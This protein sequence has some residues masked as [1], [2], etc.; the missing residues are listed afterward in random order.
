[1]RG[2]RSIVA[3]ALVAIAAV[4][5]AVSSD[6]G[7]QATA[8][9]P[10]NCHRNVPPL[11]HDGFPEPPVRYSKGGLLVTQ[12]R[13]SVSP[14]RINHQLVSTLNYD[15]SFPGPTLVICKGDR[16][17]VH[18]INDLPEPTNLHTH[19]FHVSP[20]GNHDNIFLKINPGQRF[21][22]EY[23][24]PQDMPAG[25]YWYHPHLHM[26]VERQIFAG[27]AGAIVEEGG[28][29][30]LPAL[31]KI[32]Q[33]WIVIQNTW[34]KEGKTEPVEQLTKESDAKLYVNGVID[35]TAKIR[36]GQLQRWSI[37]NANSDRFVDLRIPAAQPFILLAEDGHTLARPRVVR[38]LLVAPGSSREVL[39]RGGPH[40]TYV[41]RAAPFT[42]FPGAGSLATG[43]PAPDEALLTLRSTGKPDPMSF[44]TSTVLSHP[45][46]LRRAHVARKRT[47]VFSTMESG[48]NVSFL[49]NGMTFDPNQ[50]DVTMKL[51]S[52]EQWTL[53][54]TNEEW[55]T[56]HIHTNDFQVVSIAGK[57]V[58]YI[59]YQD[60][61]ALPP[62]S[63]TVIL[64]HPID[65]TGKFVFHCHITFHEDHGMM[66]VVQVVRNPTPT[67][68]RSS[69]VLDGG[70]TI[71]SN[72]FGSAAGR[73][74]LP[75]WR[76][77][78]TSWA[79]ADRTLCATPRCS[80]AAKRFERTGDREVARAAGRAGRSD[81]AQM[82]AE[83]DQQVMMPSEGAGA[84]AQLLGTLARV[85]P[86]ARDRAAS[87]R[88]CWTSW[89]ASR[90]SRLDGD[91]VRI[92]R[93]DFQ[94]A[95]ACRR[96]SRS[97]SRARAPT[98]R[99]AGA[100]RARTTTSPRSPRRSRATCA[101]R[102]NTASA[103]PR[104][105][106]VAMTRSWPTTTMG[107]AARTCGAVRRA[108]AHPPAARGR[109]E[110]APAPTEL[111]A[112]VAAPSRRPCRR[113]RRLG[114]DERSWRVDVSSPP[115]HGLA[116]AAR[117]TSDDALQRGRL[118]SLLS[119]LHEYGHAL[120]ERQVDP[121]LAGTNLG[122]G[123]SM[124]I[125]ESQSKLWENHV[126]RSPAFAEV[127][128]AELGQA[129]SRSLPATCMRRWSASTRR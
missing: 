62:K 56:F 100:G 29:D 82:L 84:R 66:A 89:R 18:L 23:N 128:A 80:S 22:Y 28:L 49:L 92:A 63:R 58:P 51:G 79:S 50:V 41:L 57:R 14:V 30:K 107:F 27:M 8:A 101:S 52:I 102:A 19:G 68:R 33:R 116:Q 15:G 98:D 21:T 74:R 129:A 87:S 106:A 72:A 110:R 83:W 77:S 38:S 105:A 46:D 75:R 17:I 47:I 127:L 69:L 48:E 118:E 97:S 9:R 24:I 59:D 31:R 11:I 3:G 96:S 7:S 67:Q 37:F 44:P 113:A 103:W 120:Y 25:D 43:G 6:G 5:V 65:F 55:H 70:F 85:D 112:P 64:M 40:G 2:S 16:L 20:N 61:V 39:V 121:A 10:A 119:S 4:I 81:A 1:M 42:Q 13:A 115:F 114:V 122:H 26:H 104:R 60:N 71:G 88:A 90:W 32:P 117:H 12:L 94:R 78:A 111:V 125:H 124:S 53:V 54:N 109:G 91:I 95:A 45:V 123:T 126:A 99:R 76:S 93:R 36:P 35:P 108:G 86:R 73:R 34:V